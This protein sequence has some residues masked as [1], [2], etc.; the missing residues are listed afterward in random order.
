MSQSKA[1]HRYIKKWSLQKGI[2][3]GAKLEEIKNDPDEAVS[4]APQRTTHL[5]GMVQQSRLTH[6]PE[7]TALT[8]RE[9]WVNVLLIRCRDR[10]EGNMTINTMRISSYNAQ[11]LMVH[12][13]AVYIPALKSALAEH[14]STM[15]EVDKKNLCAHIIARGSVVYTGIIQ[16]PALATYMI[17]QYYPIYT[18]LTLL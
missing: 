5:P 12:M 14:I 11:R 17:T 8:T 13:D 3:I 1:W 16:T 15:S 4:I 6:L 10:D 9:F 18:W 7:P 2:N